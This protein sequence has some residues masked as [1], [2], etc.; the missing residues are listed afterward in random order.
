VLSIAQLGGMVLPW[1]TG[2]ATIAFG[3]RAGLAVPALAAL[4]IAVGSALVWHT[5]ARRP[6]MAVRSTP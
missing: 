4:S 1:L 2:K 3:Y 5:R 6:A